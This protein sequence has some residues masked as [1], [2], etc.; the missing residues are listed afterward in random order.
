[1]A[2]RAPGAL[3][4]GPVCPRSKPSM[5]SPARIMGGTARTLGASR[6][7]CSASASGGVPAPRSHAHAQ[8]RA[9]AARGLGPGLE[10][11]GGQKAQARGGV[12]A[13]LARIGLPRGRYQDAGAAASW[14]PPRN[15]RGRVQHQVGA[16]RASGLR[17]S[18]GEA[19]V[20]STQSAPC[21]LQWARAAIDL[22]HQGVR[23]RSTS[24]RRAPRASPSAT[25]AGS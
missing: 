12:P 8:V 7:G 5:P 15:L 23:E 13:R 1:M 20:L 17:S 10:R 16:P 9:R 22:S 2:A 24:A 21:A 6:A 3:G 19:N 18:A 4:G 25:L 11:S 14:W